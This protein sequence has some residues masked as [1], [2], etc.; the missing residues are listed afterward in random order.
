MY[1]HRCFSR[2]KVQLDLFLTEQFDC[3]SITY[4]GCQNDFCH[5]HTLTPDRCVGWPN[6][7]PTLGRQSQCWVNV[8]PTILLS[9]TI[10]LN[11]CQHV[12][13]YSTNASYW[14]NRQNQFNVLLVK[15]HPRLKYHENTRH[16]PLDGQLTVLW[17]YCVVQNERRIII[18]SDL[19][20]G[21]KHY[22]HRMIMVL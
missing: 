5:S 11:C 14:Q 13:S 21:Y 9:G 7:E 19:Y 17:T 12:L 20:K 2:Y 8:G 18:Q 6:V 1:I 16:K 22:H 10:L 4:P 15:W 3:I